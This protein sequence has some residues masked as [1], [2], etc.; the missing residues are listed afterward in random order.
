LCNEIIN[1]SF[2]LFFKKR[3]SDSTYGQQQLENADGLSWIPSSDAVY[4]TD[5][6]LQQGFDSPYS[7]YGILDD[8]SAFQC[9]E[10]KSLPL[11]DPSS[12]LCDNQFNDTYLFSEQKNVNAYGEQASHL[13]PFSFVLVDVIYVL[14]LIIV[15]LLSTIDIPR[16]FDGVVA[17]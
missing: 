15:P 5:V 14:P 12:A 2:S 4:S 8:L 17:H 3:S 7:D 13:F 16:G 10:D 6:A 1:S 11:V 9:A